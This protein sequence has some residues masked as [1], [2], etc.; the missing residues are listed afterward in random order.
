MSGHGY[1]LARDICVDLD[2]PIVGH[3]L[4][5]EHG[6]DVHAW[7]RRARID[8]A[9]IVDFSASIN[10]LGPPVLARKAFP[11]SYKEVLRYPEPYG[12]ELK[13]AL[14]KRH[15]MKPA[16]ILVGNGSTQLI[17]L[18]CSALRPRK[19]LVVVPAFSEHANALKLAGAKV[20]F[21]SLATDG[22]FEFSTEKFMAAW[23]KD[24]SIA[25]LTTP[26]SITGQLI[27]RAE[28]EKIAGSARLERRLLVIDEAFIDFVEAESVKQ[29]IRHNPY[30]IILRSLTKY[31]ALPGLR[32]GYLLAHSR[33]VAQFS[34]Y[35]E[36]WSVNGPAQKVALACLADRSFGLKTE[37]WLR[38]ERNFLAYA[39]TSLKSFQPYP[40]SANF[41][42]VRIANNASAV[43]LRSFLLNKRILIRAFDSFT[44]LGASHFRIAVRRRKDNQRLLQALREWTA[45]LLP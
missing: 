45:R 29:L 23:A 10:P 22:S 35:L 40:S 18:L 8:P 24:E 15:G 6:G 25:F 34:A 20:R 14:A 5:R 2:G 28:V 41:L 17:Y 13:E 43:E 21:L 16:E 26:N 37:R 31:Y 38:R 19:A 42:L 32:L 33:R 27:P 3:A 11:K 44:G 30:V 4:D 1:S 12:E 39:L 7:A 9:E 36:P